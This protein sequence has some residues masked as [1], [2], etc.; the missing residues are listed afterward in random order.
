MG[1]L[2]ARQGVGT[3]PCS[4][5]VT[6]ASR[7]VCPQ[8]PERPRL[9]R[10]VK[11]PQDWPQICLA[12]PPGRGGIAPAGI[13]WI[14][15]RRAGRRPQQRGRTGLANHRGMVGDTLCLR[16]HPSGRGVGWAWATAQ[17]AEHPWQWLMRQGAGRMRVL[18]DRAGQAA[19]G[20]PSTRTL[21]Q[22][23]EWE[24][25]LLVEPVLSMLTLV[26]HGKKVMHR[27]GAYWHARQRQ[28]MSMVVPHATRERL[29]QRGE[30]AAH[31]PLGERCHSGRGRLSRNQRL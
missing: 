3:R 12:A 16:W 29:L 30:L 15:P 22:R 10:R 4:R 14:P 9:L 8:L 13:A 27:V 25:R 7:P 24:D 1:L 26:W 17:G 20:D 23:G 19:A 31:P 5:W 11:T 21:G 2:H 28:E 18:R 6:R